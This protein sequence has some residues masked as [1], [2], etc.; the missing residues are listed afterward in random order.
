MIFAILLK[1]MEDLQREMSSVQPGME[2]LQ[3][4]M[5]G[6]QSGMSS[7]Q[8]GKEGLQAETLGLQV[9]MPGLLAKMQGWRWE[10]QSLV[11]RNVW[12][13][14][15]NVRHHRLGEVGTIRVSGWD[16]EGSLGCGLSHLL[17]QMVLTP[18]RFRLRAH[19]VLAPPPSANAN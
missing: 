1:E 18:L 12:Y 2:D 19:P 13:Q 9:E 11:G 10:M 7:L 4:E 3:P 8:P 5:P 14:P 15:R 17:T 16:Q 6:L